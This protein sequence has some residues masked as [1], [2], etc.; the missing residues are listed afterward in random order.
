MRFY[1]NVVEGEYLFGTSFG[2][3]P[4]HGLAVVLAARA[5]NS[6][7]L[8]FLAVWQS[9]WVRNGRSDNLRRRPCPNRR[10]FQRRGSVAPIF[11][12]GLLF[13]EPVSW[14]MVGPFAWWLWWAA[15]VLV[16]VRSSQL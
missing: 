12:P 7:S 1:Y 5:S 15:P 10:L 16:G 11:F 4:A 8:V 14:E 9:V 3:A 2:M 13:L 6:E